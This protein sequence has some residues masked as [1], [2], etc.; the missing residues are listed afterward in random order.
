MAVVDN[1]KSTAE[2]KVHLPTRR[3]RSLLV[4]DEHPAL[5]RRRDL[6]RMKDVDVIEATSKAEALARLRDIGFRVDV[7]MTDLNLTAD[8]DTIEGLDVAQAVSDH[9]GQGVPLYAY[10]GKRR[11]LSDDR[12]RLFKAIVLKSATS[13]HVREIFNKASEDA[14]QHFNASVKRAESLLSGLQ[15]ETRSL[16]PPEVSLIRDLVSGAVPSS[17][18]ATTIPDRVG[19]LSLTEH[20]VGV[21]YGLTTRKERPDRIYASVIG[22]EYLYGYGA[23]ADDAVAALEDVVSGFAELVYDDNTESRL[24]E[25]DNAVGPSRRMR[26]LLFALRSREEEL[27][28][29]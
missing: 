4:E 22:H 5:L 12:R 20:G 27:V 18:P 11:V 15:S 21:P 29:A 13:S 9:S 23:D 17:W 14:Y 24:G 7:V 6:L 19:F 2:G 1:S 28:R 16:S 25:T 3:P 10:S 8:A 26:K